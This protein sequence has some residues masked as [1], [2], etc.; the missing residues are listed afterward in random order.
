MRIHR[1]YHPEPLPLNQPITL[2]DEAH[3]HLTR[4]LRV[5]LGAL[6]ELFNGDSFAY[7][8]EVNQLDKKTTQVILRRKDA[9]QKE[10]PLRIHLGQVISRGDK[11]DFTLQKAVELGVSRITP[12]TSERCGV[13]LDTQRLQKKQEHWQKVV[14]SACEQ[15]GRNL[16]PSVNHLST[17]SSWFEPIDASVTK[18]VMDWRDAQRL[19]QVMD[20]QTQDLC[21]L[22]GPEG[23]LTAQEID[24]AIQQGFQAVTLGPRIL[25]TETAA[26][27]LISAAQL[28]AGDF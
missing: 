15:S 13:K 23:G 8:G 27:A 3:A 14:I 25:R 26:L 7:H 9:T 12:L 17:L 20:A 18:V 22:V 24:T 4:V 6:V 28:L 21:I 11:M 1:L 16:V 19:S 10:S 2:T 5:K